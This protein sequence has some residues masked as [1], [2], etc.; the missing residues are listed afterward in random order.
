MPINRIFQKNW[1]IYNMAN[2]GYNNS[3]KREM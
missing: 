1:T 3:Q 2:R